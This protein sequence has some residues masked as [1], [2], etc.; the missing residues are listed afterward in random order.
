MSPVRLLYPQQPTFKPHV[1]FRADYVCF[2]PKSGRG[3][4]RSRESVVDPKP[5]FEG[6]KTRWNRVFCDVLIERYIDAP[7]KACSLD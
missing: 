3:G 2:T 5:T 4:G 6:E 1:R 7:S